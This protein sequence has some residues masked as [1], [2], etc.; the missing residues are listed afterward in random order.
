MVYSQYNEYFRIL[1]LTGG[2]IAIE[3]RFIEIE[4]IKTRKRKEI[5]RKMYINVKDKVNT[6]IFKKY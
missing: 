1:Q 6:F 4:Y 2:E 3:K 5:S